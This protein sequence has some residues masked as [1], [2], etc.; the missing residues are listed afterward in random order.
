MPG[1]HAQE[2]NHTALVI[3]FLAGSQAFAV[4]DSCQNATPAGLQ[5]DM[6]TLHMQSFGQHGTAAMLVLW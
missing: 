3:L 2:T 4:V 1:P 5:T 6:F